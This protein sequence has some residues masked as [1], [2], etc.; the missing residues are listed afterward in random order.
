MNQN[1]F[2]D[3]EKLLSRAAMLF[4]VAGETVERARALITLGYM[5]SSRAS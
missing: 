4:S 5:S 1:R 3:A 2:K